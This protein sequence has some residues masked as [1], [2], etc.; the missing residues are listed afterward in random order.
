M[1]FSD[2]RHKNVGLIIL[3]QFTS[4]VKRFYR[5]K[6][7]TIFFGFWKFGSLLKNADNSE[8]VWARNQC[9]TYLKS[10]EQMQSSD[11]RHKNVGIAVLPQLTS[12]VK[13]FYRDQIRTF[14][15]GFWKFGTLLKTLIT[16]KPFE[17]EINAAHIWNPQSKSNPIIFISKL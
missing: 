11:I 10:S 1:L 8:T 7:R 16:Q 2:T 15:F 14:F 6:I 17:L 4:K 9:W 13:R 5:D 12:K 3:P